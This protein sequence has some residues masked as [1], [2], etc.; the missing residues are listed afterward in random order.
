MERA[1]IHQA[2]Q[3]LIGSYATCLLIVY[4]CYIHMMEQFIFAFSLQLQ[5]LFCYDF[6]PWHNCLFPLTDLVWLLIS[7]N[8]DRL[9]TKR[10]S[11]VCWGTSH[12]TTQHI[13]RQEL[14]M[15]GRISLDW[16]NVFQLSMWLKHKGHNFLLLRWNNCWRVAHYF[17]TELYNPENKII[18]VN[19]RALKSLLAFKD[20][21]SS[22]PTPPMH[23]ELPHV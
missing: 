3:Y 18:I 12:L 22:S 19:L 5:C 14:L 4:F 13:L 23:Y 10:D 6:F 17:T 16:L 1:L 20:D 2:L 15:W 21:V 9:I 11:C 8:N 7:L